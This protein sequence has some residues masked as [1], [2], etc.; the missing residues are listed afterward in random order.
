MKTC[1][2][3]AKDITIEQD[4]DY[5]QVI[6]FDCEAMIYIYSIEQNQTQEEL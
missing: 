4:F 6:C 3:C 2:M 1:A 5:L